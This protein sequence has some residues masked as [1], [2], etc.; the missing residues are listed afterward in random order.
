MDTIKQITT[1]TQQYE[2]NDK[3]LPICQTN[4]QNY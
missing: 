3:N 4:L 1:V 2:H